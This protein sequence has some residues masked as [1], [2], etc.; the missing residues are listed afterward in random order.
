MNSEK[1]IEAITKQIEILNLQP[2]D[3]FSGDT[4]SRVAVKLAAYKAGLGRHSTVAKKAVWV[5]EKNLKEAK[6]RGFMKL[7]GQGYNSTDAQALRIME[8]SDEY[9]AFIEAQVLEDKITTL[10]FN[11]HDLVDAIKSRLINQQMEVKENNV[12]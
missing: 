9:D 11:V 10:S 5:A 3:D 4:L 6:A 8:A 2:L 7:K 12:H 1:V